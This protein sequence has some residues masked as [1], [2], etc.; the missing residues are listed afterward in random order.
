MT[1][2]SETRCER[3][4]L[5][6]SMCSHCRGLPWAAPVV[7]P[8]LDPFS[9]PAPPTPGRPGTWFVARYGDNCGA[10]GGDIIPGD[11]IRA[12]GLGGYEC[13]DCGNKG[14]RQ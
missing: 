10:C 3:T 8:E 9:S 4:E 11:T 6:A 7:D 1:T 12:D 2:I 5:P 14:G 13:G